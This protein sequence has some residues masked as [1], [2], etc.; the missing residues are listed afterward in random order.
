MARPKNGHTSPR[1]RNQGAEPEP[2]QAKLVPLI[3]TRPGE[4]TQLLIPPEAI[5]P[6]REVVAAANRAIAA[7]ERRA[8]S[9]SKRRPSTARFERG[10]VLVNWIDRL[11]GGKLTKDLVNEIKRH[12]KHWHEVRAYQ[13][14]GSREKLRNALRNLAD[15]TRRALRDGRLPTN[16]RVS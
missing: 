11:H 4:R 10:L 6:V 16:W 8:A 5:G 15:D 2:A 12:C 7:T 14:H 9:T 1:P 13:T 3:I